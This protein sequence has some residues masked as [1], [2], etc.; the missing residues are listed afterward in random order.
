MVNKDGDIMGKLVKKKKKGNKDN[1]ETLVKE[2]AMEIYCHNIYKYVGRP[3]L[4]RRDFKVFFNK[5]I[6]NIRYEGILKKANLKLIPEEYFITIFISMLLILF[7]S[8]FLSVSFMFFNQLFAAI[9]FFGGIFFLTIVGIF[10]YNYPVLIASQRG[11]EINAAIPYLLPYMKILAKELNLSKMIEIINDFI[12][13]KEM[14]IEFSRIHY[15]SN[16]LGYD[17]HS[18]IREAMQ[19]CPSRQLADMMNDLVTISNSGG[20][21]YSYLE[22]KLEN[23]NQEIDAIE[24]KNIDTLLIYSQIYVVLLLISPL[25]YTIMSSIL[26]MINMNAGVD[27]TGA[28]AQSIASTLF[29]LVLLPF[30]YVGFMMLVYYS[31]PLYS[32][33]KPMKND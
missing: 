5:N 20:S 26:N 8:V 2:T 23:L 9:S 19:S 22:R 6:Y 12:I 32:R 28:T 21:I 4:T 13:Y 15:Y 25:F 10:L 3:L 18:S 24:K 30:F 33:L 1:S 27:G 29:M 17:I 31:K 11:S 7:M 16:V 14:K